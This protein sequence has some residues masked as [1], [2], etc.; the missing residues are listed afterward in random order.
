MNAF[1]SIAWTVGLTL[2]VVLLIWIAVLAIGWAKRGT[3]S[4]ALFGM[5]MDLPAAG[6][7][8]RP[9]PR[10]QLE[11]VTEDINRRKTSGDAD[12]QDPR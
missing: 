4:G 3:K 11:E 5:A 10:I 7:N 6:I 8:P 1:V 9:P 2:F 12:P